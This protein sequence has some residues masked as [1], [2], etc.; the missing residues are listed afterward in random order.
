MRQWRVVI[1]TVLGC[2]LVAGTVAAASDEAEAPDPFARQEE[3]VALVVDQDPRFA[4]ALDYEYQRIIGT[5]NFD[6]LGEVLSVSYYRLLPTQALWYSPM[7]DFITPPRLPA[8]IAAQ[9]T[10]S[11]TLTYGYGLRL[12]E[13]TPVPSP[14]PHLSAAERETGYT[15]RLLSPPDAHS[16]T[17]EG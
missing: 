1:V 4:D 10:P 2:A 11:R 13:S 9:P 5:Q 12:W 17:A 8:M 6:T 15:S 16:N 7:M 14:P 3:V